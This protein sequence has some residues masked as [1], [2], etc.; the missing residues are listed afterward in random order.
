LFYIKKTA[1]TRHFD[2]V[3]EAIKS[4]L[5]ITDHLKHKGGLSRLIFEYKGGDFIFLRSIKKRE[6]LAAASNRAIWYQ[7]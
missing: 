3:K 5:L 7:K 2:I 4:Q 1:V 6:F